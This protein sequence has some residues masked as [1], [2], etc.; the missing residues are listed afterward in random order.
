MH[1]HFIEAAEMPADAEFVK[2][3]FSGAAG[4][5]VELAAVEGDV[6]VR[7]SKA[8]GLGALRFSREE[9]GAFVR[10]AKAGEFDHL[11]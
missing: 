2:S 1:K 3:S 4:H 10:G 9:I 8:P 11:I 6:A 7:H 5:C